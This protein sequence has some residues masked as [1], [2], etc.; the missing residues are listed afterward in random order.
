[1]GFNTVPH[2]PYCI[3]KKRVIYFLYMN[4]IIFVL[5]ENKTGIIKKVIKELKIKYQ[6]ISGGELQ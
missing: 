4:N 1:M 2:K 3:I 6:Y 5:R